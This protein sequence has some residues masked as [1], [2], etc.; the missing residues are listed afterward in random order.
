MSQHVDITFECLP[1][2]SVG[3]IDVP[4]DA[5]PVFRAKCERILQAIEK[6]G[7]HNTYYL[8][9]ARCV[10]HLTNREDMGMIEFSF[11]GTLLTDADDLQTQSADL[12]VRLERETCEWLTEPVVQW[13]QD[14][15]RHAVMVEFDRFIEAGDLKQTIERIQRL[16]T[17][18]D[19]SAGFMGM[20]L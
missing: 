20:Y 8:H 14:S 19:Q 18:T 7:T 9:N 1:L 11:E 13:F 16:Q 10:F 4:L 5:S 17:A 15:V 2:R 3:R 6:H 12:L